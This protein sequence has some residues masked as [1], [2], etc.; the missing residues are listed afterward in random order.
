MRNPFITDR[1]LPPD[2]LI[3]RR[4]EL[5]RLLGLA[6]GGHN[7]RL[8][9]PRRYGKTTLLGRLAR[10]AERLGL[11]TVYVNFFGVLSLD[12]VGARIEESYRASLQGPLARWFAGAV[13]SWQPGARVGVP[14]ASVEARLLPGAEGSR[15][16][17]RLLDLPRDVFERTGVRTVVVF[18]EFQA[19]L[20]ADER[21]DGLVRSRIEQHRDEASY[22]FAG[23]HPGMMEELFGVQER[24]LYGQARPLRLGPLPDA[25]LAD[26]IGARLQEG[27]RDPGAALEPLLVLVRGHPQRAM[28]LAHHLWEHT[29]PGTVADEGT[30]GT[31]LDAVLAEQQEA[32]ELTWG[33]LS[34]NERRVLAAAAWVGPHGAGSSFYGKD[35]LARFKL[36]SGTARD[37]RRALVARGELEEPGEGPPRIVDPLLEAWVASGRRPRS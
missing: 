18:D 17:A 37:V 2:E 36:T 19:L 7:S 25:D 15:F 27:G 12:D 29:P 16:L 22:I 32:F 8:T 23:S 14:G 9:A 1:P 30:W 4:E 6:E 13:R 11:H 26:F 3:D 24:P 28:L 34:A 20:G 21:V 33:S 10:D 35:T 31:T 5:A